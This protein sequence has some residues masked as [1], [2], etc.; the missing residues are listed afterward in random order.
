MLIEPEEPLHAP[1]TLTKKESYKN[2]RLQQVYG[3]NH[4]KGGY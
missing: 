1:P 3:K 2:I 4:S